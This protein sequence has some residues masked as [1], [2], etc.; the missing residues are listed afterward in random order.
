MRCVFLRCPMILWNK[1]LGESASSKHVPIGSTVKCVLTVY[2]HDNTSMGAV[3]L[4]LT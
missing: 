1:A 2:V 4:L 3:T